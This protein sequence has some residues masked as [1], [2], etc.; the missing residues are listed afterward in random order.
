MD[1]V[2]WI[3]DPVSNTEIYLLKEW[4]SDEPDQ[5]A[6]W[7]NPVLTIIGGAPVCDCDVNHLKW[8]GKSIMN[9]ISLDLWDSI[10]KY[11]GI[12]AN[13]PATYAV[14]ILNIR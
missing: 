2:F 10:K 5:V 11:L 6:A 3:F 7:E 12:G 4:S 1:A 8:S 13:G 9:I 14:V